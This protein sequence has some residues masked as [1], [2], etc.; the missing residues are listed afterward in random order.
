MASGKR[1]ST[2]SCL[3]AIVEIANDLRTEHGLSD[4][5]TELE[6]AAT[7]LVDAII[8]ELSDRERTIADLRQALAKERAK[9]SAPEPHWFP[10]TEIESAPTEVETT[11]EA[12]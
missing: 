4:Y 3:T 5:A 6:K 11:P 12:G 1:S 10:L 2:V 8:F 7:I 9:R